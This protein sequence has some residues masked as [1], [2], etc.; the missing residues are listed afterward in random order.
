MANRIITAAT[1]IALLTPLAACGS[2]GGG[3][4]SEPEHRTMT[5]ADTTTVPEHV[6]EESDV[7]ITSDTF[8][9][10][11]T[12]YPFSQVRL[13]SG[14]WESKT[15]PTEHNEYWYPTVRN[16]TASLP[17]VGTWRN[18]RIDATLT[19]VGWNGGSV[20]PIYQESKYEGQPN[21]RIDLFW[22]N[23]TWRNDDLPAA[24]IRNLGGIDHSK[25]V[26]CTW[27]MTFTDHNTGRRMPDTFTGVTGFNDLD[28]WE[29][30]PDLAFEGIQLGEGFTGAYH[31]RGA[32]LKK[33]GSNG[34]VGYLHDSGYEAD[35]NGAMQRKHR[36]AATW[37]GPS[38]TFTYDLG[39]P[40]DR[41]GGCRMT[42]GSPVSMSYP[43]YY[44]MNGGTDGPVQKKY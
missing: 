35:L 28:G 21:E 15:S 10:N 8:L 5:I 40:P 39:N 25:R 11:T 27:K 44:D 3:G 16:A 42:F 32:E 13:A 7:P 26:G 37:S 24:T 29:N 31:V 12:A 36:L 43:L 38:F 4:A 6:T 20:S 1:I 23:T 9:L 17:N 19:L 14:Q 30:Q 34:Y 18:H 2:I 41:Q 33:Y 22:V